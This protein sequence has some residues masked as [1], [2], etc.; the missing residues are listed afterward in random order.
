MPRR[1]SKALAA[2]A[3]GA[4]ATDSLRQDR[5]ARTQ[6][7]R[8][9]S[10][11]PVR[12]AGPP[13]Q[14]NPGRR[15][16]RRFQINTTLGAR[17]NQSG[18]RWDFRAVRCRTRMALTFRPRPG[19]LLICNAAT[20]FKAEPALGAF[21]AGDPKNPGRSRPCCCTVSLERLDWVLVNPAGRRVLVAPRVQ[22][23]DLDA[24]RQGVV[25]A[26]GLD[27]WARPGGMLVGVSR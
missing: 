4:D 14:T 22:N 6:A 24:I 8:P 9:S 2:R 5:H 10:R 26:L 23:E 27:A 25:S 15:P 12:A 18:F 3:P 17:S 13:V 7:P 16:S 20:C 1:S 21:R 11:R 19:T